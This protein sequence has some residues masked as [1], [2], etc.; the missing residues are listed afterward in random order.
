MTKITTGLLCAIFCLYGTM[1]FASNQDDLTKEA[2]TVTKGFG[3]HLKSTLVGAMK[4]GGPVHA[5]G[6]CNA[7]AGS[8]TMQE[9]R[10]SGWNIRRTSLK[11]RNPSNKADP[12]EL[13]VLKDFE[14]RKAAGENPKTLEHSAI[15]EKDGRKVFRYMKAIPTGGPCL[16]CHGTDLK[17]AVR[18]KIK[19]LYPGD[20]ATGFKL[21]DIRGAFSL[22][23]ELK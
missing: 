9:A 14:T 23:K 8:I 1:A 7:K 2:R 12:W 5:L 18:K 3:K 10:K 20:K 19:D 11:Q 15:V 4:K 17:Q 6:I 21:G 22:S 13:T 16:H